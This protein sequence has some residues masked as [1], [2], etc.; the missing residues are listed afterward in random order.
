MENARDAKNFTTVYMTSC[1]LR[2]SKGRSNPPL[3]IICY[4]TNCNKNCE[5]LCVSIK[6]KK[7]LKFDVQ[8]KR[9]DSFLLFL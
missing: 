7:M 9:Y 8:G 6:L 4:I 3:L 2:R 1:E 5:I